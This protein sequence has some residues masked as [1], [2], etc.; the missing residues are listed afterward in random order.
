MGVNS[1]GVSLA[2]I[3]PEAS[4]LISLDG[5]IL[6][7]RGPKIYKLED[8]RLRWITAAWMPSSNWS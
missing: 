3:I 5:L 2:R 4:S 7:G 6:K 1:Y 8:G